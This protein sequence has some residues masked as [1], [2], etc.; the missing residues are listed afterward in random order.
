MTII[1]APLHGIRLTSRNGSSNFF[2]NEEGSATIETVIWLPIFTILLTMIINLSMVF[3]SESQILRVVQDGN[4]AF[5][6]GRLDDAAAVEA[7]IGEKLAYLGADVLI[8]STIAGGEIST[9]LTTPAT[10]LMPFNMMFSAFDGINIGVRAQH[11]IE[12]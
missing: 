1:N 12:F 6:L 5:S 7:Y 9:V 10:N 4:R 2:T 11:L 8:Q 3:F